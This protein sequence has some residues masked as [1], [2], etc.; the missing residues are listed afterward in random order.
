MGTFASNLGGD[1][2]T[3]FSGSIAQAWSFG[4]T[5][6]ITFSIPFNYNP[7]SGNLLL[8]V[9]GSG[10][11]TPGGPTAFDAHSGGALFTRVFC[12]GGIACGPGTVDTPGD[13]W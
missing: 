1:V 5:L 11:S 8:D 12:G 13:G 10:I 3:V 9:V 6:I 4:N 7:G 2:T